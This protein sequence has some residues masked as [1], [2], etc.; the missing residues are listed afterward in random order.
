M[1]YNVIIFT[2]VS[3]YFIPMRTHGA[4]SISAHLRDNGYTVKVIDQQAWLW[5]NHGQ[6]LMEYVLTLIGQETIFIGF[7]STFSRYFGQPI[8]GDRSKID[9]TLTKDNALPFMNEFIER[10]HLMY[11]HVKL[12]LGGKGGQTVMF[13]REYKDKLDLWVKGLGEDTILDFVRK[14]GNGFSQVVS[15]TYSAKFDFHN[16]KNVFEPQD[17]ILENESLPLAF[18]RGCRF[19]CKFCRYPLL[20]RKPTDNY[21]RNE[22]SVYSELAYNLEK[23]NTTNYIITD[24]T[25][26][27]TTEKIERGLRAVKRTGVDMNFWAYIRIELLERFPEQIDLLKEMGVKAAFFGLESLYDPSS[28]IIGKGIGRDRVLTTLEKTK[29]SWGEFSSLHGSFIVG[30]PFETQE[31]ADE[32]TKILIDGETSLDTISINGLH[33]LTDKG[34]STTYV[35][36]S[37]FEENKEL[38]GYTETSDVAGWKNDHWDNKTANIYSREVMRQFR[39]KRPYF[40]FDKSAQNTIA[41]MNLKITNPDMTWEDIHKPIT[42]KKE[43]D[44]F[45]DMVATANGEILDMY[46]QRVFN[47]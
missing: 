15:D 38:Y 28:R 24:D 35:E 47:D 5:E 19:K 33:L 21:V 18:S 27:E 29:K 31:T 23:F 37:I 34:V 1:K 22:E 20:G 36:N 16:Q 42:S 17:N 8:H 10:V 6:E 30:L 9:R 14:N 44:D 13:F 11:P 46:K 39:A 40:T 41:V 4:F 26:N 25:F 12:V 32:W 43:Y 7:S 2:D 45:N 3:D